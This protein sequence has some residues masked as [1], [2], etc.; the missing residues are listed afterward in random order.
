ME[1]QIW[2]FLLA[3]PATLAAQTLDI[4][5]V[6][7]SHQLS[8]HR[9]FP[10]N[11]GVETTL[12]FRLLSGTDLS[13]LQ[14]DTTY[15]VPEASGDGLMTHLVPTTDQRFFQLQSTS[16][17]SHR[18]TKSSQPA[19]H[20]RQFENALATQ[21]KSSF[22]KF[23]AEADSKKGLAQISF[24]PTQATFFTEFTTPP[25]QRPPNPAD[26]RMWD[27]SLDSAELALFQQNGFVVTPRLAEPTPVDMYYKLW[28]DD[29]PVFITADSILDAWHRSF[30]NILEELE[31]LTLYAKLRHLIA[32]TTSSTPSADPSN[33]PP[34]PPS[35]IATGGLHSQLVNDYW[36]ESLTLQQKPREQL[37]EAV[38]DCELYLNVAAGLLIGTNLQP[39][40]ASSSLTSEWYSSAFASTEIEKSNL[41]GSGVTRLLDMTLLKVRGHYTNSAVLEAYFQG[42]TW[43]AIAGFRMGGGE[44]VAAWDSERELRASA[45]LALAIRD[46]G[47]LDEWEELENTLE[48]FFGQADAMTVREMVALLETLQLDSSLALATQANITLLQQQ[49]LASTFGIREIPAGTPLEACSPPAFSEPRYFSLFAQRWSPGSWCLSKGLFPFVRE[50][51]TLLYRRMPS[52]LDIAYSALGNCAVLPVLADRMEDN[53]GVPFR[54]GF[55]FHHNLKAAHS[56]IEA[57]ATEFW[58][59]HPYNQWLHALRALSQPVSSNL[60][61]TFQTHAWQLR[62]ANAQL[63]SWTQLRYDTLL[64]VAQS[65]TPGVACEFPDGYVEP[66]PKFWSRMSSLATSFQ[67]TLSTVL[68]S[69]PVGT[70]R[71]DEDLVSIFGPS[72]IRTPEILDWQPSGSVVGFDPQ[73]F[74]PQIYYPSPSNLI[75]ASAR[76]AEVTSF[77]SNFANRSN[78]LYQ[79]SLSQNAG[80]PLNQSQLNFIKSTVEDIYDDYVGQRTYQGWFPQLY[81]DSA[82]K[83]YLVQ[84]AESSIY[85][86]VVID[87]HTDRPD[88]ICSGDPG[89]ILHQGVGGANFMLVSVQHPNGSSC[90]YAGPVFSHYE[91]ITPIGTR[92]TDNDWEQ[93]TLEEVPWQ[94]A[95]LYLYQSLVPFPPQDYQTPFLIDGS[96]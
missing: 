84:D 88:T 15:T 43:L 3:V 50:N 78:T 81:L 37:Q 60:S 66:I 86:P 5:K 30:S 17:Y 34:T 90:T 74:D 54:D 33:F 40:R 1:A 68:P 55:D 36:N 64:Y 41:Y 51:D 29:L 76:Q 87:V 46:S 53:S 59:D 62:L 21:L 23:R 85:E 57:Q 18:A 6:G 11:T 65:V 70:F 38:E 63:G 14:E 16:L 25:D 91:T 31:E 28:T 27:F 82:L 44:G 49:I 77:L 71:L 47:L 52:S 83:D 22:A 13:E 95:D 92:L 10:P 35:T 79:I 80:T 7:D 20:D 2:V 67:N 12:Q 69:S 75:D 9:T 8:W 26:P 45:L 61:E 32:H 24:D 58:Q 89:G 96:N 48:S 94:E 56:V 19:S 72:P 42:F 39:V 73:H 4:E 93:L